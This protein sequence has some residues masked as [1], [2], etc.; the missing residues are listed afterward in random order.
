VQSRAEERRWRSDPA[1]PDSWTT[2]AAAEGAGEAPAWGDAAG[3]TALDEGER[4]R[5]RWGKGENWLVD[6]LAQQT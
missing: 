5:G 3:K 1:S 6:L 2:G 4:E